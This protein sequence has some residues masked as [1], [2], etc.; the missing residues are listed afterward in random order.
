MSVQYIFKPGSGKHLDRIAVNTDAAPEVKPAGEEKSSSL[1]HNLS[2]P[3]VLFRKPSFPKVRGKRGE[4]NIT[5]K[6]DFY[7]PLLIALWSRGGSANGVDEIG[8]TLEQVEILMENDLLPDDQGEVG[9]NPVE[10]RWRNN[11]K[12]LV[13]DLR[14]SGVLKKDHLSWSLTEK[15]KSEA[16][17][18]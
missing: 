1:G 4:L 7:L 17:S 13:F 11:V 15:G 12:W 9:R 16:L 18:L 8:E 6:Q 3:H 14:Q 10:P 5:P 2:A